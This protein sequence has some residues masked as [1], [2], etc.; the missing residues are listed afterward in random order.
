VGAAERAPPPAQANSAAG[1]MP[2]AAVPPAAGTAPGAAA[3]QAAADS[4]LTDVANLLQV[5]GMRPQWVK[6]IAPLVTVFGNETVNPVSAPVPV[7]AALGIEED[8]LAAFLDERRLGIDPRQLVASLGG[9]QRHFEAKPP[10]AIAVHLSAKL[11]DGYA[12]EAEAVIVC[13]P[14]DRQLYRVL[15]WK[16]GL[17]QSRP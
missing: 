14:K 16:P 1:T 9:A 5:P 7:L 10:Q 4:L 11:A 8:R 12:A 3:T 13:L 15:A 6:A 17:P 2:A